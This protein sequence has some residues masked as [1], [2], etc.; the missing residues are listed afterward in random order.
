MSLRVWLPLNGN[1]NNQGLSDVAITNNGTTVNNSGKIGKCYAFDGSQFITLVSD[2]IQNIFQTPQSKFSMTCWIYLNSDET[3]RVIIFGNYSANPFVNWELVANGSQRL[4]VGGTSNYTTK[5]NGAIV[6]KETWT[7]IA[8]TY[9]GNLTTFYVNGILQGAYSG[10]NTLTTKTATNTFWLGSDNRSGATRLKGRMNDFRLYDHC[11]SKKEVEEI[12]KGLVLHYPLNRDGFGNDNIIPGT[13]AAE[14]QYTYPS[15]SYNDKFSATTSIIPSASQY[16]ASFWA[17]STVNGDKVR[18]HWYSPNTTTRCESSQGVVTTAT[19]GNIN[20]TLSTEW[21][22]YWVVYTQSSTTAV[23]RFIFPRM[24]SVADQPTMSGTGIVSIK[25]LKLEEGNI[26]TPWVPNSNDAAYTSMAVNNNIEYDSSGYK[27]NGTLTNIQHSSNTARYNTSSV[28]NGSNSYVKVNSN[29]WMSQGSLALTVSI[30][31]YSNDWTTY[32]SRLWSC[33]EGGG[34]NVEYNTN[35]L[36]F[37]IN[38]YT[39]ADLSTYAYRTACEIAKNSLSAGWHMI[40]WVYSTVDRRVY[41]DGVLKSTITDT[42]Y[43]LHFNTGSNLFLGCESSGAN[44]VSPF[45]NGMLSDF[46]IYATTLTAEQVKEL[47]DTSVTI[48]KNGNVY[49]REVIED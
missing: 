11:L 48:D 17:K 19:D 8:V 31:A 2:D 12:S 34:F 24:G 25:G 10:A 27:Y 40:T 21:K 36:A 38:A 45:F 37:A 4:C 5:A 44:G 23:K 26:P 6:P 9:D 16:V 22:Y 47:Y 46:R 33:T 13:S 39:A 15:T 7:H 30:W 32:N 18:M 41:I 28:F 49:A 3:D 42:T 29:N 35:N 20:I 14:I 1:L 43:G